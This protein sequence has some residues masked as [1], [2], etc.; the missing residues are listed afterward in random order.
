M[1]RRTLVAAACALALW[2]PGTARA[3][4]SYVDDALGRLIAVVDPSGDTAVYHYDAVG[5]LTEVQSPRVY[6]MAPV[7]SNEVR[8]VATDYDYDGLNQLTDFQRGT[9]NS[10]K[11]AITGPATA[12]QS[13]GLD[14]LGNWLSLTTNGAEE[15]RTKRSVGNAVRPSSR[16]RASMAMCIVGTALN[17]VAFESVSQFP[18]AMRGSIFALSGTAGA[19]GVAGASDAVSGRST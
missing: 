10:T 2:Q 13:W 11:D 9:L 16:A 19:A 18:S 5:N 1:L 7:P 6:D 12:T 15:D 3:D 14:A 4:I 8:Y 17:Q